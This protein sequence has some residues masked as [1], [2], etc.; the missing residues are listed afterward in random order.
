MGPPQPPSGPQSP[1]CL[2]C[3]QEPPSSPSILRPPILLFVGFTITDG[4]ELYHTR[5]QNMAGQRIVEAPL[6]VLEVEAVNEM[7][8][9][10]PDQAICQG[11]SLYPTSLV[12][13]L[14]HPPAPIN[15]CCIT[16]EQPNLFIRA[17]YHPRPLPPAGEWLLR[18]RVKEADLAEQMSAAN[19]ERYCASLAPEGW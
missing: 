1:L 16:I 3:E 10:E 18:L 17:A 8:T 12:V 4:D 11:L 2:P 7:V 9:A 13:A 6:P 5:W 14:P 19:Y 15:F